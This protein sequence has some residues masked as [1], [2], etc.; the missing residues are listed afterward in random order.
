MGGERYSKDSGG[1][2]P[3]LPHFGCFFNDSLE[4]VMKGRPGGKKQ[5]FV[6]RPGFSFLDDAF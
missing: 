5:L 1:V 6:Q 3:S 4:I 2:P